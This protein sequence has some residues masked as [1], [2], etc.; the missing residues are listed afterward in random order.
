MPPKAYDRVKNTNQQSELF[1]KTP[2]WTPEIE[3]RFQSWLQAGTG[4]QPPELID[5]YLLSGI[6]VSFKM[7]DA[8]VCCT[9]AH[10]TRRESQIPCLLTGWSDN[11]ADA[12][13]VAHFKIAVLLD[14]NWDGVEVGRKVPRR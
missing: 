12:L 10:Q 4:V 5:E 3:D 9:L 6:A 14:G 7:L 1:V 8:S 11:W 13:L 2:Y